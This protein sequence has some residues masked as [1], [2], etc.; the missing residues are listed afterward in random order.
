MRIIFATGNAGKMREIREIMADMDMEICSMKEAGISL[1]IEE[2]G[3][4]FEENAQIKAK[5]VA[6]CTKDI[7]LADD[8]GL[9]VDYLNKEPGVYSARYLGEDTSY[10]IKNQAILDRLKGVPKEQRTARFVCA[11]AAVL[12]DGKTLVTRETIEGYIGEC[13][14]GENGFGYDPIFYVDE[15]HCSTAE[16]TEE[17]KNEI[18]HRGKAL[19]SM[20]KLFQFF[21]RGTDC[22]YVKPA[23]PC[24][25]INLCNGVILFQYGDHFFQC[26]RH[27]LNFKI[28]GNRTTDFLWINDRCVFL[29][30]SFLFQCLYSHLHRNSRDSNLL[31]DLRIRHPCI[32]N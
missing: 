29:N 17:Q 8:S 7:V 32:L 16:L 1:D 3:T 5:A 15:Y 30:D 6:A 2:N 9:E 21:L 22:M 23:F 20:K 14:A 26:I 28:T 31:S 19:R 4:T 13:P 18:S 11:I 12:P 27:G 25:T 10:D 24:H